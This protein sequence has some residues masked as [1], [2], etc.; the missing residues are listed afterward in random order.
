MG[1][2]EI[3]IIAMLL[4]L[5]ASFFF[6]T[7]GKLWGTKRV[8]LT[9]EFESVER[10]EDVLTPYTDKGYSIMVGSRI[11][12]MDRKYSLHSRKLIEETLMDSVKDQYFEYVEEW[13]DCDDFAF[14]AL[15]ELKK[16]LPG[17]ACFLTILRNDEGDRHA[18]VSCI[19]EDRGILFF[20]AEA[21]Q[22][23]SPQNQTLMLVG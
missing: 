5:A 12:L 11:E 13:F 4:L 16:R 15:G 20:D 14:V 9:K 3:C 23:V 21:K 22:V 19:D 2:K 1:N 8:N 17:A 6:A 7:G 10:I 18:I